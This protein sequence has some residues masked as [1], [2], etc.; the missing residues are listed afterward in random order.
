MPRL[1]EQKKQKIS[2]H[3]LSVL[4]DNFPRPLF[5]SKIAQEI[6]RDE[7]FTKQLLVNLK[8]KE[9]IVPITKN[10]KG[11]DY[12]KRTRWRLSNQAHQAYTKQQ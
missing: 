3:I 6:A 9:V 5:T 1:S 8:L 7:E 11:V 2:E 10:P 12:L 4:Y